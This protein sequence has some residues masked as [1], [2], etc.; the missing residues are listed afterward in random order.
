MSA[1]MAVTVSLAAWE[2]EASVRVTEMRASP[3]LMVGSLTFATPLIVLRV[4]VMSS[5]LFSVVRM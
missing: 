4:V 3:W 2:S 1:R 5:M